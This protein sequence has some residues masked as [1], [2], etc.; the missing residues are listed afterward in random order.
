MWRIKII[1]SHS[2]QLDPLL[3]LIRIFYFI[4]L[5]LLFTNSSF[6]QART[7]DEVIFNETS[8]ILQTAFLEK[9]MQSFIERNRI[10]SYVLLAHEYINDK[11]IPKTTIGD[12]IL[13]IK[14]HEDLKDTCFFE[15]HRWTISSLGIV[16][17][18]WHDCGNAIFNFE[19][20]KVDGIWYGHCFEGQ[21]EFFQHCR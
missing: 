4:A 3:S 1:F 16:F 8:I 13:T 17:D 12:K 5:I 7:E 20:K 11:N 9:P 2:Y 15:I 18:L 10:N 14:N 6:A 21:I 19:F